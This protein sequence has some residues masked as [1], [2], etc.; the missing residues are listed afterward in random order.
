MIIK[1]YLGYIPLLFKSG[2]VL[3]KGAAVKPFFPHCTNRSI[4][5]AIIT[6]SSYIKLLIQIINI[7]TDSTTCYFWHEGLGSKGSTEIGTC[8]YK[9]LEKVAEEHPNSDVIFYSDN[10]CGQQKNRLCSACIIMLSKI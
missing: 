6:I 9:F 3:K 5:F 10:C 4:R 7:K 1:K 8:V 2:L